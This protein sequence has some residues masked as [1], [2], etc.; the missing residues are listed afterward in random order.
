MTPIIEY[1]PLII[2]QMTQPPSNVIDHTVVYQHNIN[3][4][5]LTLT[6]THTY[7]RIDQLIR[8]DP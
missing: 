3:L 4:Y 5:I 1:V 8:E 7:F 2:V 6:R